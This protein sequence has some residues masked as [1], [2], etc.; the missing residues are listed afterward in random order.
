[1][2]TLQNMGF[3]ADQARS[4]LQ[5]TN[6]DGERAAELPIASSSSLP[7]PLTVSHQLNDDEEMRRVIQISLQ[8]EEDRRVQVAQAASTLTSTH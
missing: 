6:N 8:I 1:V 7:P 3:G 5:A 4:A 2:Q